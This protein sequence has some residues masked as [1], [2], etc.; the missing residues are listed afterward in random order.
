MYQEDQLL[1]VKRNKEPGFGLYDFPGGFADPGETLELCAAREI[2]EELSLEIKSDN[3]EYLFSYPNTYHYKETTYYVLDVFFTAPLPNG[4][5]I[6]DKE[7][8]ADAVLI[9]AN[10]IK[11]E[12][13][14]FE[15]HKLALD[16]F[17]KRKGIK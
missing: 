9:P 4:T 2:R 13:L 12:K 5:L 1:C 3:L 10:E 17:C 7:E 6:L 8:I 11:K 14:A 15:S 16:V